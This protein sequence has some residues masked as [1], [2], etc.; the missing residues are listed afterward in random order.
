MET[1]K[2][3]KFKGQKLSDTPT[4]YQEWLLKQDWYKAPKQSIPLYRQS[5][6]GWDGYSARGQAIEDAIF[7]NDVLDQDLTN[8]ELYMKY[9]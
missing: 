2:F 1:L 9:N 7:E 4:W 3:G 5:L 6:T 8:D